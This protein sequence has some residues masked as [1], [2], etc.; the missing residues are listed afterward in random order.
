MHASSSLILNATKQ[1]AGLPEPL[2][3]LA[4]NVV[5]SITDMKKGVL[6]GKN[7]SLN[8]EEMLI[9]LSVSAAGNPSA[10]MAVEQLGHLRGCDVHLTHIPAPGDEAGLRRLGL[11]ITSDPVFPTR[12]LFS[13]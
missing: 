3:L 9:A 1:L 2:H 4:P 10:Q 13:T 11:N 12:E 5:Q 7:T 6:R 8:L